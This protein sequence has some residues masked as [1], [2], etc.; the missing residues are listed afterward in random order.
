MVQPSV[1]IFK[2]TSPPS[3]AALRGHFCLPHSCQE[4]PVSKRLQ[5]SAPRIPPQSFRRW[6]FQIWEISLRKI[7]PPLTLVTSKDRPSRS[8]A[9]SSI[10]RSTDAPAHNTAQVFARHRR[11]A[12]KQHRLNPPHPVTPAQVWWQ[13]VQFAIQVVQNGLRMRAPVGSKSATFLV[14]TCAFLA[15]AW[16]AIIKS[17]PG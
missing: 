5:E 4:W 14:T 9:R 8:A 15:K 2:I 12:R 16:A 3:G 10:S 13:V 6:T 17:A 1:A 7:Q 11:C